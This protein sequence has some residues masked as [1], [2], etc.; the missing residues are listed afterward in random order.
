MNSTLEEAVEFEDIAPVSDLLYK[1]AKPEIYRCNAFRIVE[2]PVDASP[3]AIA[4]KAELIMLHEKLGGSPQVSPHALRLVPAAGIEEMRES[5]QRIRNPEYWIID[6]LFWFWPCSDESSADIAL[7]ELARGDADRAIQVWTEIESAHPELCVATHNLA[8]FS[9]AAALDIELCNMESPLDDETISFVENHWRCSLDRWRALLDSDAF[10]SR[11]DARIL[12]MDDPRL[13][14]SLANQMHSSLPVA[15]L[16]ISAQLALR[17]AEKKDHRNAR[18]LVESMNGSGFELRHIEEALRQATAPVRERIK[19]LCKS[20]QSSVNADPDNAK[21]AIAN[22]ISQVSPLLAATD[23]L[24]QSSDSTYTH[25]HDEIGLCL[26]ACQIAYGN[27][28]NDWDF[29]LKVI[30][31]ALKTAASKSAIARINENREIILKNI[32]Y[33][34][35]H[36]FCWFCNEHPPEEACTIEHKMHGNVQRIPTG[37]SSYRITWK[38]LTVKVPRCQ[39]CRKAH[40]RINNYTLAGCLLGALPG[41]AGC[42]PIMQ[43]NADDY[44]FGAVVVFIMGVIIGG[45]IGNCIGRKSCAAGIKPSSSSVQFPQI[46]E[47]QG[48]GWKFG[49]KPENVQ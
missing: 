36:D 35:V 27:K 16:S 10:W 26:L 49:E 13:C 46:R 40:A 43:A 19:T 21:T 9:H 28:T 29:S 20:V 37:Y 3:R 18:R 1:S 34:K 2:L 4:R 39:E 38:Y 47:L 8:V 25:F 12:A 24:F 45:V 7:T 33:H 14:A 44:W 6:E 17:Y 22:L 32:E 30:D 41:L 11:I 42:I 5:I 15:L 23:C 31:T 48:Q